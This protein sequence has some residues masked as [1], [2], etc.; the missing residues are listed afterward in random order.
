M[1][2]FKTV[3]LCASFALAAFAE[4]IHITQFPSGGAIAGTKTTL[5]WA[6]GDGQTVRRTSPSYPKPPLLTFPLADH[7]HLPQT[8]RLHLINHPPTQVPHLLPPL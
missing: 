6:G 2:L 4:N 7:N 1:H 5:G 8:R 3:S